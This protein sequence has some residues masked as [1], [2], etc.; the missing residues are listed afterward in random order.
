M[1]RRVPTGGTA[2]GRGE[3][4]DGFLTVDARCAAQI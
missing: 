4:T 2:G 3:E 1:G